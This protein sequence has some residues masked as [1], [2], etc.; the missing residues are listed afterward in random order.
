M[1]RNG[2]LALAVLFTALVFVACGSTAGESAPV[3]ATSTPVATPES[4]ISIITESPET[5]FDAFI[6]QMP[7]ADVA[8]LNAELGTERLREMA[9]GD[10]ELNEEENLIVSSCF[11][12]EFV[13]G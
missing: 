10:I 5:N 1:N 13:V 7:D 12:N 6:A 11:S 3:P 9:G 2:L 4:E 8:C